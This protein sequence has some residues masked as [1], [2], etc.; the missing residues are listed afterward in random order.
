MSSWLIA[1]MENMNYLNSVYKYLT[2]RSEEE[3]ARLFSLVPIG[4]V[5]G[6]GRKL[7]YRHSI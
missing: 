7:S 5:R 6:N 2:G 4:T 3:G 1:N